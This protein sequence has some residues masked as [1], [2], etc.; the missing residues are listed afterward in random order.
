MKLKIGNKKIEIKTANS[1]RTRL[2]GLMGQKDIDYGII[3][4]HCNSIHTFFMKE[5]IDVIGL[6]NENQVIYIY[7]SVPKNKIIKVTGNMKKTHI[8]ELP[9]NMSRKFVVGSII[10]F[11]D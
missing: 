6:N 11:E 9:N 2:M 4:P 10:K 3:F 1:F 8:L 5:P 7:H